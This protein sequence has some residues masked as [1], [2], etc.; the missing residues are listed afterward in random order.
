MLED[1]TVIAFLNG[2]KVFKIVV[3]GTPQGGILSVIFW[4]VVSQDML[5]RFPIVNPTSTNSFADDSATAAAGEDIN[6]VARHIKEA[7]KVLEK[8]ASDNC[9]KV[10]ASKTKLMLFTNSRNIKKPVIKMNGELI[11]YVSEFKYLG[12]TFSDNFS[13]KKHIQNVAK[14]ATGTFMQCRTMMGRTWGLSPKITRWT[15]TALI[16]PII[17]YA[18]I[19][20]L[21]GTL[22]KN[23]VKPLEK[24]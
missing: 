20:W 14:R 17:S 10:N 16:R 8:W 7:V 4:N 18:S 9:L 22:V 11:E 3:R 24:L 2:D 23:Q 13:W 19:I 5:E 1:R 6:A 12:V 15:Y 21:K